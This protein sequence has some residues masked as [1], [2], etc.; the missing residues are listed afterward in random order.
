MPCKMW[1]QTSQSPSASGPSDGWG[2]MK[3]QLPLTH[4]PL[5][6][7]PS[8]WQTLCRVH[9]C[10]TVQG[11]AAALAS[12]SPRWRWALSMRYC[13][14]PVQAHQ[15]GFPAVCNGVC[16]GGL[17][18]TGMRAWLSCVQRMLVSAMFRAVHLRCTPHDMHVDDELM[19]CRCRPFSQCCW[20]G[21]RYR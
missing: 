9:S 3:R 12:P 7:T 15:L 2:A 8:M 4:R 14:F 11:L 21:L 13:S 19:L 1:K 16:S 6:W 5:L 18:A 10:P 17:Q 20:G